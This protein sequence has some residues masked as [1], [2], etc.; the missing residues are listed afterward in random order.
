MARKN[1]VALFSLFLMLLIVIA[2][3][4]IAFYNLTDGFK[5]E[6]KTFGV[7]VNGKLYVNN[8]SGLILEKQS[9]IEVTTPFSDGFEV[10]VYTKKAEKDFI[11]R[12]GDEEYKWSETHVMSFTD[13]FDIKYSDDSFILIY[14]NLAGILAKTLN[15]D[16]NDIYVPD[17]PSGDLFVM[18]ISSGGS[19]ISVGFTLEDLSGNAS[20][21]GITLDPPVIIF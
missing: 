6:L 21:S 17:A 4:I 5:Y 14:E 12:I 11:F 2:G 3:V 10:S 7:T 20:V 15:Y 8:V 13:G 18:Y 1:S 19:V 16:V 9:E